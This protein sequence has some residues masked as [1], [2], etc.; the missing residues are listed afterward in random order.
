MFPG[1]LRAKR[2]A[3]WS[4][5]WKTYDAVWYMGTALAPVAGSGFS[6][7]AWTA[8]VSSF[9]LIVISWVPLFV[10]VYIHTDNSVISFFA[11]FIPKGIFS[12][13]AN[14]KSCFRH[15]KTSPKKGERWA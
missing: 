3:A 2:V 13:T 11:R 15:L 7:P 9:L 12:C 6:C 4:V 10:F 14:V 5:L 8:I 1:L